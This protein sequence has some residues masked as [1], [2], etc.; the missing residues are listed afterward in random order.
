MTKKSKTILTKL[1]DVALSDVEN[2]L[3]QY[4]RDDQESI[5]REQIQRRNESGWPK[6]HPVLNVLTLGIPG[7]VRDTETVQEVKD[8]LLQRYPELESNYRQN[9]Y[10]D[11]S[12]RA[13]QERNSIEREK[14]LNEYFS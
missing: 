2:A 5:A 10:R 12:V 11:E 3:H 6:R 8:N 4:L 9:K 1:A 7:M 14:M 13:Q